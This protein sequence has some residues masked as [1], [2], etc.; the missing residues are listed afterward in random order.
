M[1]IN[2]ITLKVALQIRGGLDVLLLFVFTEG[3]QI[4]L[5]QKSN[6]FDSYIF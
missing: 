4:N 6:S 5:S 3:D 2:R 1:V